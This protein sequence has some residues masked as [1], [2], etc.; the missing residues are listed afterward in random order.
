M[1]Q[2][3]ESEAALYNQKIKCNKEQKSSADV[4]LPVVL[5]GAQPQALKN[6]ALLSQALQNRRTVRKLTGNT[7]R[8]CAAAWG[9]DQHC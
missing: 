3:L 6:S 7:R 2:L 1:Y 8:S 9:T 5:S 4:L